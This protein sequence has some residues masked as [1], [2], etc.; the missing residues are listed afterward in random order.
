[1]PWSGLNAAVSRRTCAGLYDERGRFA[2]SPS[3]Q[4]HLGNLFTSLLALLS[5]STPEEL[6][7][8][9]GYLAGLNSSAKP[10]T[11]E[12]LLAEFDWQRIPKEDIFVPTGLF[13]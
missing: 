6:V 2:P 1:M 10:R 3:G 4:M 11:P 8:K 5:Q 7:G 13:F 12:S 9:L